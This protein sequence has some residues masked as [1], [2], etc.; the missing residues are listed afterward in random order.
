MIFQ[1]SSTKF[2]SNRWS[3]VHRLFQRIEKNDFIYFVKTSTVMEQ[4][5]SI[6]QE[7][8]IIG[9]FHSNINRYNCRWWTG[10]N[11]SKQYFNSPNP[12]VQKKGGHSNLWP[13]K[14][15]ETWQTLNLAKWSKS[16]SSVMS[17]WED[18]PLMWCVSLLWASFPKPITPVLP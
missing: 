1:G 17:W 12:T 8:N 4:N 5:I 11:H 16:P 7:K 14:L 18:V 2:P 13:S 15:G 9:I 6:V 10:Y 3:N